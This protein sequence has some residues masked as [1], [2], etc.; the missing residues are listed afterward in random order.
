MA[1]EIVKSEGGKVSALLAS[2]SVRALGETLHLSQKQLEKANGV[3]IALASN[4]NLSKC[5]PASIIQFVYS[6]ARYN[7]N[8]DDACYPVPYGNQVQ[9]QIGYQGW[10]ELAMRTGKYSKIEC[11]EIVEGEEPTTDEDGEPVINFSKDFAGRKSKKVIGYYG[12]AKYKDGSFARKIYWTVEELQKHAKKYSKTYR[13]GSGLWATDFDKMAK[14][15]I[16][17]FVC[18]DLDMSDDMQSALN[19]DQATFGNT[20]TSNKVNYTYADNG[21]NNTEVFDFSGASE[22][23]ERKSTVKNN[24]LPKKEEPQPV[25][26]NTDAYDAIDSVIGG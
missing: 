19:M 4:Q 24:I 21:N 6:T 15:T 2:N 5:T 17:K 22:D 13:N 1:N 12:Y 3:A 10:K 20:I 11:K 16:I 8:R 7:F 9:A 25:E 18:K 23:A 14:K 26:E